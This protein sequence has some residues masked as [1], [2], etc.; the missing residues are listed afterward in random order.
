MGA[1]L[2]RNGKALI[3]NARVLI[4]PV[5]RVKQMHIASMASETGSGYADD[6]LRVDI[7]GKTVSDTKW[8]VSWYYKDTLIRPELG[9]N[10]SWQTEGF[11]EII[12][13][14]PDA[15]I[16]GDL[17]KIWLTDLGSAAKCPARLK[18]EIQY[19]GSAT[20][21]IWMNPIT[22]AQ[23]VSPNWPPGTEG[24]PVEM[25]KRHTQRPVNPPSPPIYVPIG[26]FTIPSP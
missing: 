13:K 3:R 23:I 16:V 5:V 25:S 10:P 12:L 1:V 14:N 15:G 22:T 11:R 8:N 7:A 24:D 20:Q 17:V 18:I 2:T 21:T 6:D 4:G 19:F 9:A 26:T